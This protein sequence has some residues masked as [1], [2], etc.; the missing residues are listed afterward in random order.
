MMILPRPSPSLLQ[1]RIDALR[2]MITVHNK[3]VQR[4]LIPHANWAV[5]AGRNAGIEFDKKDNPPMHLKLERDA[6]MARGVAGQELITQFY[7]QSGA[8]D[9]M[10]TEWE[11]DRS[12]Q[13]RS[14]EVLYMKWW[15]DKQLHW[16]QLYMKELFAMLEKFN[17]TKAAELRP[18]PIFHNYMVGN[19]QDF[20][21]VVNEVMT[22]PWE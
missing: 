1:L 22:W 12:A 13:A 17:A 8:L 2:N 7:G 4:F 21:T 5:E 9:I 14:T 3:L 11:N 20:M 10:Y 19:F 18:L 15:E 6:I 16:C